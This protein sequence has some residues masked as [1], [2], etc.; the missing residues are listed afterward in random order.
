MDSRAF[1]INLYLEISSLLCLSLSQDMKKNSA[2][3]RR[4]RTRAIVYGIIVYNPDI[5]LSL[6]FSG[7]VDYLI[8]FTGFILLSVYHLWM[9]VYV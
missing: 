7:K 2:V 4:D 3:R 9:I 1:E 8:P 6:L 5:I